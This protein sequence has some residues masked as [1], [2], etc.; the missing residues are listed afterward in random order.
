MRPTPIYLMKENGEETNIRIK[1]IF[2]PHFDGTVM[3]DTHVLVVE[4]IFV[5]QKHPN[6]PFGLNGYIFPV[7]TDT[8]TGQY[9]IEFKSDVSES[10]CTNGCQ[11]CFTGTIDGLEEWL[12]SL[13]LQVEST[14]IFCNEA[15]K[16]PVS[17]WFKNNCG[18][19]KNNLVRYEKVK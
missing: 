17:K 14:C 11:I 3:N 8:F 19:W 4:Y 10:Y 15:K 12:D 16:V 5:P 2:T 1:K 6:M 9:K 13:S 7:G 18:C